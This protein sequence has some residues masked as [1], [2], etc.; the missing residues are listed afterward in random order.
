MNVAILLFVPSS[1]LHLSTT[2]PVNLVLT[3]SSNNQSSPG[4]K[5]SNLDTCILG[6][7]AAST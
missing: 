7:I 3:V 1:P 5:N 6:V 2:V 4:L